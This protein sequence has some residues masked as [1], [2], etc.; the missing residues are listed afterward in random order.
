MGGKKT[1]LT[2]W[3][4]DLKDVID[5]F[6][7]VGGKDSV[8]KGDNKS[9][10]LSSAV[11]KLQDYA[12]AKKILESS[13]VDG[14]FKAVTDG[15]QRFIGYDSGHYELDGKGIGLATG[16]GGYVSSYKD[17]AKWTWN[18]DW[19]ASDSN[20][21]T[22]AHILLGTMPLLY[23]G[24]TYLFWMC[25]KEWNKQ[26]LGGGSA[27]D[28]YWFMQKMGYNSGLR[29][30]VE[31]QKIAELLVSEHDPITDFTKVTASD[32]PSY[33]D[34]LKKLHQQG[35]VAS[36]VMDFP[37]YKLYAA[38]H[39]YLKTKAKFSIEELP[40][41][42]ED[43]DNMITVY[44]N[45]ICN[46]NPESR[47]KLA[48][49]YQTLLT[50]IKVAFPEAPKPPQSSA[51]ASAVGEVVI[52]SFTTPPKE[53]K[54]A[55]DWLALVGGGYGGNA[56]WTSGKYTELD[57]KIRSIP[58]WP[59]A[60]QQS[61]INVEL[62]GLIKKLANGLGPGFLGYQGS[63]SFSGNGIVKQQ[64]SGYKSAYA[65]VEWQ[66]GRENDCAK[67]FLAAA[68][69][70]YYGITYLYWRCTLQ[71]DDGWGS[72]KISVSGA[73]PLS[74]FM[75]NMG[76]K[77]ST[78]LQNKSGAAIAQLLADEHDS[79]S[80]LTKAAKNQYSY[81]AFLSEFEA[82]NVSNSGINYPLTCCL[83]LA[84]AYFTSQF[85]K[86]E[87][88]DRS[89]TSIK[90]IL[91]KFSTLCYSYSFLKD[92]INNF[93]SA[94]MTDPSSPNPGNNSSHSSPAAP[95]AGTLSTLGLGGGAAAAYFLDHGGAKTLV[96]GLLKIG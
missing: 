45:A 25:L 73:D 42:K 10:E 29:T 83:K 36:S 2:D 15:L 80:E 8:S 38:S 1:K 84:K 30:E 69:M 23:F 12:V 86:A 22:C 87:T 4:E 65:N 20:S 16:I 7:R 34:F 77:P 47:G 14:L 94:Y 61:K 40:Q 60:K 35:A 9:G 75:I 81:S 71:H 3:P 92:E 44:S 27:N 28:I 43:I 13:S 56:G 6:L 26:K 58:E 64:T 63:N 55:I 31:G 18:T 11:G 66:V 5:W 59:L 41:Y 49:A 96:N 95:V 52:R 85:S 51:A 54:E 72:Y 70:A 76:F 57:D 33:P 82:Q 67:V 91:K 48:E 24:L 74:F 68:V 19:D 88:T 89:L 32:S 39:T 53:L 79:F 37:L 21:K 78:D 62:E 46:L 50:K 90:E 93:I 17:S